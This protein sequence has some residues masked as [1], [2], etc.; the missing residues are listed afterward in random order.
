VLHR[1][2]LL[3]DNPDAFDPR[4]FQSPAR[5]AIDRF[6]YLPFGAG[7][8]TCVGSPFA[9]QEAAIVLATIMRRFSLELSPDQTVWPLLQ[10]TLRPADGLRMIV[11]RK[12]AADEALRV[13]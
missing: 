2:K 7:P 11:H 9:M 8:R 12:P 3:W 5:G 10:V 6:A 4:R 13:G 1:H